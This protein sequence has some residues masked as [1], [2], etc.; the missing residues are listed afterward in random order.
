MSKDFNVGGRLKFFREFWD[1]IT[2]DRYILEA[3]SGVKLDFES[4]PSQ[5]LP[6]PEIYCSFQE[7]IAIEAELEKYLE[8][9]IISKAEH[10]E[11][12]FVS[13]IFSRPKKNGKI[14]IILDLSILNEDVKYEHFKMENFNTALS[15]V[16]KN[17]YFG[18]IDL[19]D[20]YYSVN[21]DSQYRKYLR[22]TWN[23]QLYEF[24]CLPNGYSG[25]PRL[26]TKLMKPIFGQL[27]SEGNLSVYYLDD[28]LQI[29]STFAECKHNILTTVDLLSR[30]GFM[31]NEEKSVVIPSQRILFLGFWIDSV[32]MTVT[33]P[34]EKQERIITLGKKLLDKS[35]VKI[36]D[37]AQFI[38]VLVASLPAVKYGAL[39]YRFLEKDK[40]HGLRENF[41]NFE[42]FKTLCD[43]SKLEIN[44][45]LQNVQFLPGNITVKKPDFIIECDASKL[46]WG[47][48]F[49][50]KSAQGRWLPEEA[51]EHINVLELKAI[52]FGLKSFFVEFKDIHI[53]IKTDNTTAVAYINNLG[54]V[55]SLKCHV[56]AKN[57]WLWAMERK[58]HISAEHLPGSKNVLAD[59]ASRI[60]DKNTEW[61]LDH[62]VFSS[63][64]ENFG[65][66]EIDLFA[67][68]INKKYEKYASWKPDP[69]SVIVDAFSANWACLKFYAFPPFS[70]VLACVQKIRAEQATGVLVVPLWITQ[71]W[72]PIVMRMLVQPPI[73]SPL[74]SLFLSYQKETK[75]QQ[76]KNLRM[77]A[78]HLSGDITKSK[79]FHLG[80]LTSCVPPGEPLPK[81]N[82]KSILKNGLI[83]VVDRRLIP[84]TLLKQKS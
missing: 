67:S 69:F 5:L 75:H 35:K 76:H 21:I 45:W 19:R 10:S 56:Q 41:G 29:G 40:I 60:F 17:C 73:V 79:A 18:S 34:V 20:A 25:A 32:T 83:S 49:D 7:K 12:Q 13:K 66:L 55:K 77:M 14:R 42:K 15:L 2:E 26:F 44:W 62:H 80:P 6:Q 23:N 54:G 65:V 50:S 27:R 68:R 24:N 84:C 57:I 53:R 58:I 4:I 61:E 71:P 78:C 1:S 39:F 59:K 48:N 43:Q 70:M 64:Q 47:V 16:S 28:S 31:I 8:L 30:A 82:I 51:I 36:R 37:L 33:L 63:I 72:F 3:I 38:G 52:Y 46:G 9:G 81:I 22:F 11:G 74:N